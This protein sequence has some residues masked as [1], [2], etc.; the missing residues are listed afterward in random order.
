V[1]NREAL[2]QENKVHEA[3]KV[4]DVCTEFRFR[5]YNLGENNKININNTK[6]DFKQV[7]WKVVG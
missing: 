2:L 6:K 7:R 4:K 1:R 5:R 3:D